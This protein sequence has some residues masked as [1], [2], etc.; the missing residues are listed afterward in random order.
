MKFI[1][2]SDK[3]YNIKYKIAFME[4]FEVDDVKN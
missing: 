3:L 4:T 1:D 2:M